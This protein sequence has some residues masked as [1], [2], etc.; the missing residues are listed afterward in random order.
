MTK[1]ILGLVGQA[2]C[3]KGTMADLLTKEYHA[4][5][6]RFSNVLADVLKRLSL[7]KTRENLS[8]LSTLLRQQFGEDLLSYV[9][10]KD[11]M[12]ATEELVVIDGIRRPEDI[13][14]L[15]PS[16][17]FKLI[18]IDAE[19]SLRFERMKRRGEKASEASMTWEQFLAEEQL[20]TEITIPG[21]MARAAVTLA[22]NGTK[23]AFEQRIRSLMHELGCDPT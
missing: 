9:V 23:E 5:Y 10:E 4:A 19:P 17:H 13:V 11:A 12:Q 22:N 1:R 21:V 6:F 2:G 8:K 16:P 3:G 20:E 15:E 7:E 14:G 18:A